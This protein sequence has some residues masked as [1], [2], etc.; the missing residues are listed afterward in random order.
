MDDAPPDNGESAEFTLFMILLSSE[1]LINIYLYF[2][3]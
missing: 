3:R 1:F 2:S